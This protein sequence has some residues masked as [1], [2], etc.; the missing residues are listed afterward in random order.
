MKNQQN[1][2]KYHSERLLLRETEKTGSADTKTHNNLNNTSTNL[3]LNKG[4]GK[5]IREDFTLLQ[6]CKMEF[7]CFDKGRMGLRTI[8]GED[9]YYCEDC[10]KLKAVKDGS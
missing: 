10:K 2:N 7:I 6:G 1:K 3:N 4:C 9:G 8:C 5:E